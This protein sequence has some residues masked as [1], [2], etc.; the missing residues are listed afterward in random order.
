MWGWLVNI[1]QH[2]GAGRHGSLGRMSHRECVHHDVLTSV[3]KRGCADSRWERLGR[4]LQSLPDRASRQIYTKMVSC[5]GLQAAILGGWI[6]L[7]LSNARISR[8][9][10]C[11]PPAICEP[12]PY[13]FYTRMC[14][15]VL[16]LVIESDYM[17]QGMLV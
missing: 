10:K 8:Y 1:G 15:S 13:T 7:E 6:L 3:C 16:I 11:L 17:A 9:L 2:A 12:R 14:S 5:R 4:F